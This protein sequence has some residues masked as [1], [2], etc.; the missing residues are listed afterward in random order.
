LYV[1]S[2]SPCFDPD[3][4]CLALIPRCLCTVLFTSRGYSPVFHISPNPKAP[5][6]LS[7][8]SLGRLVLCFLLLIGHLLFIPVFLPS[9]FSYLIIDAVVDQL[10]RPGTHPQSGNSLDLKAIVD[11]ALPGDSGEYT[12][13]SNHGCRKYKMKKTRH[14]VIWRRGC[15]RTR[16]DKIFFRP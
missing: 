12:P 9:Q 6:N 13:V 1:R 5:R 15:R 3:P 8:C 2:E 4:R 16:R 14:E 11:R 10:H 7:L